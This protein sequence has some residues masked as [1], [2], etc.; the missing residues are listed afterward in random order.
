MRISFV[1][2][3][4]DRF[5]NCSG[6]R[7]RLRLNVEICNSTGINDHAGPDEVAV[8]DPSRHRV[9]PQ[10][11]RIVAISYCHRAPHRT[12]RGTDERTVVGSTTKSHDDPRQM[13][14][15][16]IPRSIATIPGANPT[17][18]TLSKKII[19]VTEMR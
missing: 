15:G 12:L 6:G 13:L 18:G 4:R 19:S 10:L 8:N 1:L 16:G 9:T 14:P 3:V 17:P 11:V 2:V 7:L 5:P